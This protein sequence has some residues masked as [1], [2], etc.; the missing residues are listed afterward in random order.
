MILRRKRHRTTRI[1][2]LERDALAGLLT[3]SLVA[4]LV[5]RLVRAA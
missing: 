4:R 5:W 2:R 3:A 1:Q